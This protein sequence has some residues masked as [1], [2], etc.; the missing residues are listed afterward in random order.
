LKET[1]QNWNQQRILDKLREKNIQ[2]YFN[3]PAASHTGGVWE[4][5][6][7]SIRRI[8][9]SLMGNQ[10]LD[11]ETLLTFMSEV[12]KILND[13]PLVPCSAD[14]SDL[15]PLTPNSLLLLRPN[16]CT[17]A[18]ETVDG[19]SYNKRRMRAQQLTDAFWERWILEYLPTLQERQKWLR[20]KR[21]LQEGDLVLIVGEHVPRG[22]WPKGLVTETYP[23]RDGVV[24]QVTVKTP[25]PGCLRR[26]VRK[27][28]LLECSDIT[29]KENINNDQPRSPETVLPRRSTRLLEKKTAAK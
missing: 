28:C 10:L 4:R 16:P 9:R 3:A 8:L 24:R 15:E 12:E 7:R 6:I 18:H 5:M 19:C 26:D 23:D 17:P 27:L 2:W 14:S 11:D 13:R 21:N 29:R 22:Q 25:G 20:P 1:L